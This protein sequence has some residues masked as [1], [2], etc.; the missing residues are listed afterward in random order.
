[1]EAWRTYV[2]QDRDGVKPSRQVM[3]GTLHVLHPMVAVVVY[4]ELVIE[5]QQRSIIAARL[6]DVAPSR[7]YTKESSPP[8]YGLPS[9]T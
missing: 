4:D 9:T 2:I 8:H 5:I 7:W 6:E 1:M 3:H